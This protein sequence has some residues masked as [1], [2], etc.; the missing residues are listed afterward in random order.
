MSTDCIDVPADKADKNGCSHVNFNTGVLLPAHRAF[1]AFVQT[2][3]TKVATSTIAW[4][5]DQPA[6]NLI[7][8][9]GV[10]GHSL[11]PAVRVPSHKRGADG[12]HGVLRRKRYPPPLGVLPNWLLVTAT[13]IS[14]SGITSRDRK[15]ASRTAC[16]TYQYGDTGEYADGKRAHATGWHRRADPRAITPRVIFSWFRTRARVRVSRATRRWAPTARRTRRPFVDTSTKTHFDVRRCATPSRWRPRSVESSCSPPLGVTATKFGTTS[17]RVARP[18]RRRSGYRTRARWITSTT[19]RGGSATT[20]LRFVNRVSPRRARGRRCGVD[21]SGRRP[22]ETTRGRSLVGGRFASEHAGNRRGGYRAGSP[23]RMRGR[24]FDRWRIHASSRLIISGRRNVLRVRVRAGASRLRRGWD[25]R[26][27]RGA[28]LL[29]DG[30]VGGHGR[31]E[32]R[33]RTTYEPQVKRHWGPWKRISLRMGRVHPDARSTSTERIRIALR[34]GIGS[35][36][37][38]RTSGPN[39]CPKTAGETKANG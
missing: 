37:P 34:V 30:T 26:S 2:W 15:T 6:F 3:K 14:C 21:R 24:R 8:H 11:V 1:K 19:S 9:E 35:L 33:T 27:G 29:H 31:A 4:M 5:R 13:R 32:E 36:R 20:C 39:L 12:H 25:P 7:T 28:V 10:G 16:M 17:T 23:R 22:A 38:P 18:V